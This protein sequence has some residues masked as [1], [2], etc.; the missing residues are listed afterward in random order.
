M[1]DSNL[2]LTIVMLLYATISFAQKP[3]R[4]EPER[5]Y[6]TTIVGKVID[7]DSIFYTMNSSRAGWTFY[8]GL[9]HMKIVLLDLQSNQEIDTII[10]AYV[11]NK[12]SDRTLY[13]KRFKTKNDSSYIR[14]GLFLSLFL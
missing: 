9:Y 4:P 6:D 10:V 2:R 12:H 13:D 11:Y 5:G 14:F 8:Y 7:A 3:E 1:I